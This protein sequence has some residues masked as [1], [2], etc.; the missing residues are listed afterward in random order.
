MPSHSSR[1]PALLERA[2][3]STRRE[4]MTVGESVRLARAEHEDDDGVTP[5]LA[6]RAHAPI[7]VDDDVSPVVANDDEHRVLLPGDAHRRHQLG[8]CLRVVRAEMREIEREQPQLHLRRPQRQRRVHHAPGETTPRGANSIW[9][10]DNSARRYPRNVHFAAEF[11]SRVPPTRRVTAGTSRARPAQI[12]HA[13]LH[14]LRHLAPEL[15]A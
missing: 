9:V 15:G 5:E 7:A 8:L 12:V 2:A 11:G 13:F 6:K 1:E 14:D 4:A 3:P 10:R